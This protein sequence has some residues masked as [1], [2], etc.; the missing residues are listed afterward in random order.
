MLNVL[1]HSEL[2][3]VV[4]AVARIFGGTKLGTGGLARAYSAAVSLA[5][6]HLEREPIR[7]LS[8][9]AYRLPFA[10]EAQARHLLTRFDGILES[11]EYADEVVIRVCLDET[12]LSEFTDKLRN[13][14]AGQCTILS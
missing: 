7:L 10:F 4:A 5:L 1:V 2:S 9:V 12:R 11:V 8:T 13:A 6:Q 3:C 14:C